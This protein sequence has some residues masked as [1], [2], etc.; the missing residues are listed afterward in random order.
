LELKIEHTVI[1]TSIT[2]VA[3]S[4]KL[5]KA[6]GNLYAVVYIRCKQSLM[7]D[8]LEKHQYLCVLL[9]LTVVKSHHVK[10]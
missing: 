8:Q 7:G 5:E 2:D 4:L 6:E 1:F 10:E 3:A 9:L